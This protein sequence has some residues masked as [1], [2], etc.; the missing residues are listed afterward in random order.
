MYII[1]TVAA[2]TRTITSGFQQQGCSSKASTELLTALFIHEINLRGIRYRNVRE[3]FSSNKKHPT[4]KRY[5]FRVLYNIYNRSSDTW[6]RT[7]LYYNNAQS[8]SYFFTFP[9][10]PTNSKNS[11][12]CLYIFLNW[13]GISER[14]YIGVPSK[15]Y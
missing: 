7:Y 13:I 15:S 6:Q 10:G 1:E 3:S 9:V 8:P 14:I 2:V 11:I 12:I 5:T 4:F